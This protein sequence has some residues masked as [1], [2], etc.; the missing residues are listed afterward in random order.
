[1][2]K[3]R[4]NH[5]HIDDD[6]S[7]VVTTNATTTVPSACTF[8]RIHLAT[9]D[10]DDILSDYF[11]DVSMSSEEEK[12]EEDD[13]TI[14][15]TKRISTLYNQD[16]NDDNIH[17]N[18]QPSTPH[19]RSTKLECQQRQQPSSQY[20]NSWCG[21]WWHPPRP[22]FPVTAMYLW[23]QFNVSFVLRKVSFLFDTTHHNDTMSVDQPYFHIVTIHYVELGIVDIIIM[24]LIVILFLSTFYA[25]RSTPHRITAITT[26][27]ATAT[28]QRAQMNRRGRYRS[29]Q[30]LLE[31]VTLVTFLLLI[32][33][34]RGAAINVILVS[35]IYMFLHLIHWLLQSSLSSS[36]ATIPS[37][38][39]SLLYP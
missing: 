23:T 34:L 19:S 10:E 26:T 1:M 13:F 16:S 30:Y 32:L 20:G 3:S 37:S 9:I 4:E 22:P 29:T 15:E 18:E 6:P 21:G 35:I 33:R 28:H 38:T 31:V 36:T 27:T 7:F 11:N 12:E 2:A 24:N 5:R 8:D 14:Q 17:P 39:S 25:Y